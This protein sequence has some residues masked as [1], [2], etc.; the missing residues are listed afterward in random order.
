MTIKYNSGATGIAHH[1]GSESRL[2]LYIYYSHK[3]RSYFVYD[4]ESGAYINLAHN[5][6]KTESYIVWQDGARAVNLLYKGWARIRIVGCGDVLMY[7]SGQR[8]RN[9]VIA[10]L[11]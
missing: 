3:M 8:L 1:F 10:N 5:S 4:Y 7:D 11:N 9:G 2:E 6:L